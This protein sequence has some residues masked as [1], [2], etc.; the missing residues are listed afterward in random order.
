MP[1]VIDGEF[2]RYERLAQQEHP[3][4]LPGAVEEL[5]RVTH[6]AT[7]SLIGINEF[8]ETEKRNFKNRV[9]II[10]LTTGAATVGMFELDPVIHTGQFAKYTVAA[11]IAAASFRGFSEFGRSI[12]RRNV[13]ERAESIRAR[14]D[15]L[16][17]TA[18]NRAV[19]KG[20]ITVIEEGTTA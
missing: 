15:G 6:D 7:R 10:A 1:G 17:S 3:D 18:Y 12:R 13:S 2:D 11:G 8:H 9:M 14:L 19:E 4:A 5:A 16:Y 20:V